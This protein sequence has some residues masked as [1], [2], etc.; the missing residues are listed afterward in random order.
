[1]MIS[2]LTSVITL[3]NRSIKVPVTARC[4]PMTSLLRR[5]MSSPVFVLVKKRSDMLCR[6]L[7]S[8]VR[9]SLIT[10][11]PTVAL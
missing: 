1:M 10:P 2:A 6:W 11:S 9:R 4:A 3:A 5:D 7:N 8:P